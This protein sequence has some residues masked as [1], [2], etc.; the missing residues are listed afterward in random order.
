MSDSNH[1][2]VEA[3]ASRPIRVENELT[4][5]KRSLYGDDGSARPLGRARIETRIPSTRSPRPQG[6]QCRQSAG[7]L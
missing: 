5:L 1:A 4:S 2:I 7:L 6:T 3:A